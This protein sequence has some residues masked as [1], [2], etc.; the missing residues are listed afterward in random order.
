[1][2]AVTKVPAKPARKPQ[3]GI[4]WRVLGANAAVLMLNYGDRAA[5]GV[6]APLI[7]S[8]FG[9]STGTM[10]IILGA[11]AFTYAPACFAGGALADKYGPRKTMALAAAWWSLCTALTAL[12]FNFA[13]FF[14]QRLLFGAGE[15]PQGA[16]TARTMANWFPKREYATAMGLTFAANPLGAALGIPVVTG[17]LVLSNNNWRIPFIVLGAIGLVIA[18]GWYWILRDKPSDHPRISAEELALITTVDDQTR[19]LTTENVPPLRFYLRQPAVIANAL[20]F[21]GFSWLLFMFLSW[22]PLY[23]VQTQHINLSSLAWAG[24]L[25]WV[26][27]SIGTALGG[28]LSDRLARRSGAPF[29]VRKW[30]TGIFL[31]LSGA[32][33][34][35][36]AAVNSLGLAVGLF[37]VVLLLLYLANVQFFA[38]VRDFVH[39]ARLGGVT[40]FVHFCANLAGIIAPIVT[41]FLIQNL[42]SWTAAFGLA[43]TLAILGAVALILVKPPIA[44]AKDPEQA[45]NQAVEYEV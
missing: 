32:L 39:P 30:T 29:R 4:R 41:G 16:V 24:S 23:L 34:L 28:I 35:P 37:S 44:G 14:I 15:G 26:A 27:G 40:G 36:L 25:P 17:L 45:H 9:L 8:E 19:E 5:L 10:G 43:A 13:T 2:S 7:I 3:R 31:A 20:A 18:A 22:Y 38:I 1:M 21:F 42:G 12:C 11:F 33:C 6:A